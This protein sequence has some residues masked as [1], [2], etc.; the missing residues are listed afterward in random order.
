MNETKNRQIAYWA[1]SLCVLLILMIGIGGYTRLTDSGL[2]ITEWKPITGIFYPLTEH[3]WQQEFSKY[4]NSPEFKQVNF[5]MTLAEFKNIYFVE[6]FHRLFGRMLGIIFLVP[7]IYFALKKYFHDKDL[8]KFIGIFILG[9]LQGFIGWY[10]VKSGLVRDPH[11]SHFRLAFHLLMAILIYSCLFWQGLNYLS[12]NFNK[13][14]S[15]LNQAGILL[16]I[17]LIQIFYGGLVAGLDAGKLYNQFPLMGESI[18]PI[19][20]RGTNLSEI[21]FYNPATVQFIHRVI[22]ALFVCLVIY[23][24]YRNWQQNPRHEI[25]LLLSIIVVIQF[26]LGI[27]TLLTE[28]NIQYA[29]L[30]QVVAMLII[31]NLLLLLH[32]L[33]YKK[34]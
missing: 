22:G 17:V 5:A 3:S 26:I 19:E 21:L 32:L 2:S 27:I 9:A 34:S 12:N 1:F 18:I 4:Q 7:L 31:S 16:V 8:Y 24:T 6:Y 15:L 29:L 28:V 10:M 25:F 14:F 30:H 20:I 33:I 23:F 13:D 11:V